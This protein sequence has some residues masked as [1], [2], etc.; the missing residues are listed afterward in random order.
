M[1]ALSFAAGALAA[2]LSGLLHDG[3]PRPMALIMLAGFTGSALATH[4]LALPKPV[5]A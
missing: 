3:T 4:L 1:G 2:S 5:Q